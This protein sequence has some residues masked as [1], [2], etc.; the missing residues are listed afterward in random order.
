[1]PLKSTAFARFGRDQPRA[2]GAAKAM[3]SDGGVGLVVPDDVDRAL[4]DR[5]AGFSQ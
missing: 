3:R 2:R 4:R 5:P 1:L